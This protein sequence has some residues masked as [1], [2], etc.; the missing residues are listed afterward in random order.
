[1]RT[2]KLYLFTMFLNQNSSVIN[3]AKLKGFGR[4]LVGNRL[5]G[6]HLRFVYALVALVNIL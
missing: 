2:F 5:G 1:M 4:L 6:K 3:G